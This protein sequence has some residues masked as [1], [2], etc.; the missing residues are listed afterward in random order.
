MKKRINLTA[1]ANL[2]G[3][4]IS[5]GYI[6]YNFYMLAI[7]PFIYDKLTEISFFGAG[8]LLIAIIIFGNCIEYVISRFKDIK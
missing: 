8:C 3:I 5:G 4:L 6:I 7:Y 2:I 1:I